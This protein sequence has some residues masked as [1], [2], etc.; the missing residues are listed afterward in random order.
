MATKEKNFAYI[1]G[2]NLHL[3]VKALGWELDYYKF[4]VYLEEKY[5]ITLV[6]LFIGYKPQNKNLYRFLKRC[7]YLL[8]FKPIIRSK[9]EIKGNID[10]NLIL[11]VM[12]DYH[13]Q[14]FN[15][16]LIATSDGDFYCLIK[17]LYDNKRLKAVLSPHYKICS[18][19][20]KMVAREKINFMSNLK[21]R[22]KYKKSTV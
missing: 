10:A 13:Y 15:K 11:Q 19:L 16:A 20:L 18:S 4:R 21:E 14:R 3:G 1:D 7:G 9:N 22:L 6:Y 8:I 12:I 5:D 17:Y 2:Q